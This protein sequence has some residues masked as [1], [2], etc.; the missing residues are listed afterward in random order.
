MFP[1]CAHYGDGGISGGEKEIT[2]QPQR[3]CGV[4]INDT[5]MREY[6]DALADMPTRDVIKG[7]DDALA[8]S[9]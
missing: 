8:E 6:H 4:S 1:C 7:F 2:S 9:L 5:P 3:F